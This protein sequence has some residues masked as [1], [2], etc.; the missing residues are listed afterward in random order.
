MN[1]Y[2]SYGFTLIE[3]MITLGILAIVASIAFPAYTGYVMLAN[4]SEGKIALNEIAMAQERFFGNNNSYT[5][6]LS[7]LAGFAADPVMTDKGL[8]SIASV[9]GATGNILTSFTLTATPQGSQTGDSCTSITLTST[10]I[11]GGLP[12]KSDCW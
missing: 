2:K 6:N 9:A 12:T 4:R 5:A 11:K 3:L 1:R 8:Y 7:L 10:G